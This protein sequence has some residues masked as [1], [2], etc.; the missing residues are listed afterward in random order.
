VVSAGWVA[1][2]LAIALSL[3]RFWVVQIRIIQKQAISI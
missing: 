1:V 2:A 3:G